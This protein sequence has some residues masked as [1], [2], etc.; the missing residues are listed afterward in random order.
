MCFDPISLA[1]MGT[2]AAGS[3]MSGA[4]GLM[5][6][7]DRANADADNKIAVLKHEMDVARDNEQVARVKNLVLRRHQDLNE[8]ARAEA[9]GS[10]KS[11]LRDDLSPGQQAL[12]LSGYGADRMGLVDQAMAGGLPRTAMPSRPGAPAIVER[13]F[14]KKVNEAAETARKGGY[15][16]ANLG[17]FNNAFFGN[18]RAIGQTGVNIK[19]V[20]AAQ[21]GRLATLPA[22]ADLTAFPYKPP[23][24]NPDTKIAEP[25]LLA[26][27]LQAGGNILASVGGNALGG[28]KA[29]Q[30]FSGFGG[31]SAAPPPATMT[32]GPFTYS[33]TGD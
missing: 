12:S 5:A 33:M 4:G 20:N 29:G 11:L 6:G 22:E 18:D 10:M 17:A 7:E 16:T 28:G 30:L 24:I 13:D 26:M 23:R 25:N 9:Q 14:Q 1:I 3:A 32:Q 19:G 27:G 8:Q 21:Q 31:S 15:A 2:V